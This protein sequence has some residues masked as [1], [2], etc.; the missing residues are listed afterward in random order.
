MYPYGV[1]YQGP[2]TKATIIGLGPGR[3]ERQAPG[4]GEGDVHARAGQL[5]VGP[6]GPGMPPIGPQAEPHGRPECRSCHATAI[7]KL[8]GGSLTGL[9]AGQSGK[10]WYVSRTRVAPARSVSLTRASSS[11]SAFGTPISVAGASGP[12][13]PRRIPATSTAWSTGCAGAVAVHHTAGQTSAKVI[14]LPNAQGTHGVVSSLAI[15]SQNN[16]WALVTIPGT[17]SSQLFLDRSRQRQLPRAVPLPANSKSTGQ[18]TSGSLALDAKGTPWVAALISGTVLSFAPSSGK[19]TEVPISSP[20]RPG[21]LAFD[22]QNHLVHVRH[23]QGREH[24]HGVGGAGAHHGRQPN[25]MVSVMG[26]AGACPASV[27]QSG[28]D[29]SCPQATVGARLDGAVQRRPRHRHRLR[30]FE[31]TGTR[32]CKTALSDG[33]VLEPGSGVGNQVLVRRHGRRHAG[34]GPEPVGRLHSRTKGATATAVAPF[35]GRGHRRPTPKRTSRAEA[36][37][38]AGHGPGTAPSAR[39]RAA[40]VGRELRRSPARV[41]RRHGL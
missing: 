15:D 7:P 40:L 11:S 36:A 38:T 9:A 30:G 14:P 16:V 35:V 32:F 27:R 28:D 23:A 39:H 21:A 24:R 17:S 18:A 6:M 25:E 37:P 20:L 22:A 33:A 5:R 2:A 8:N 13:S 26:M 19:W 41:D 10:L 31:P 1:N 3:C 4:H 29:G 12:R 34:A